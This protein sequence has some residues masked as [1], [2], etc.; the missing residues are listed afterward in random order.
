VAAEINVAGPLPGGVLLEN[1]AI[2][3]RGALERT[4]GFIGEGRP[5]I[6]EAAFRTRT[7]A[8]RVGILKRVAEKSSAAV[9]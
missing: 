7:A 3:P 5:T 8:S 4:R 9:E 1:K 2:D 6:L